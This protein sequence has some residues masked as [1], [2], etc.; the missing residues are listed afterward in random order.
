MCLCA[1]AGCQ[2]KRLKSSA[3]LQPLRRESGNRVG[4]HPRLGRI[5]LRSEH[6]SCPLLA[7]ARIVDASSMHAL[8]HLWKRQPERPASLRDGFK[9]VPPRHP[10]QRRQVHHAHARACARRNSSVGDVERDI[11][12][13]HRRLHLWQLSPLRLLRTHGPFAC[14]RLFRKRLPADQDAPSKAAPLHQPES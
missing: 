1:T 14:I 8:D 10:R 9:C 11:S 4:Q 2:A 3:S 5:H 7:P 6:H 12:S 13:A